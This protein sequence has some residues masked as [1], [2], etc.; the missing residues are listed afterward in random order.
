MQLTAWTNEVST[1]SCHKWN[2]FYLFWIKFG[3]AWLW[4]AENFLQKWGWIFFFVIAIR[5]SC[6]KMCTITVKQ[7]ICQFLVLKRNIQNVAAD[8]ALFTVVETSRFIGWNLNTL[9]LS[10]CWTVHISN[11]LSYFVVLTQFFF[12]IFAWLKSDIR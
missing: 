9:F 3:C 11:C 12:T 6:G 8:F 4:L 5:L 10:L 2:N 7:H 1:R